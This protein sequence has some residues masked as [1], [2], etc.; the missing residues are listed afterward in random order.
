MVAVNFFTVRRFY[1]DDSRQT[2]AS[3]MTTVAEFKTIYDEDLKSSLVS[4]L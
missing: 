3:A 1:V 4:T 2:N